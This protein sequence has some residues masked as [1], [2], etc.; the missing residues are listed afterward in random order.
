LNR[1]FSRIKPPQKGP[2]NPPQQGRLEA[3]L[4][5]AIDGAYQWYQRGGKGLD[6]PQ[7]VKDLTQSQ[8][9]AQDSVGLW[10]EECCELVE[11]EWTENTKI[12][13]SYEN[14]CE[15][16]GYDPKK[17][18][19]LSQSLAAHGCEVSVQKRI[20]DVNLKSNILRGVNGLKI[21]N[22]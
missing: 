10:L 2:Q 13:T 18:K 21:L 8:R 5:W 22:F 9:D 17:A 6:T 4:A 1:F 15:A 16:N 20:T 3:A 19:G 12:R 7:A 14:W 11:G